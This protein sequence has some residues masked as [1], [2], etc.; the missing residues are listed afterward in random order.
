M[1]THPKIETE[2]KRKSSPHPLEI[3][4]VELNGLLKKLARA[5][6][7]KQKDDIKNDIG[8]LTDIR[9]RLSDTRRK[10]EKSRAK[11]DAGGGGGKGRSRKGTKA[12]EIGHVSINE[13]GEFIV[14]N[15]KGEEE[16]KGKPAL[17][18]FQQEF[19]DNNERP[20]Q[21]L[22]S[23]KI[24][25][26]WLAALKQLIRV[27]TL[28]HNQVTISASKPQAYQVADY[29][30][31]LAEAYIGVSLLGTEDIQFYVDGK[32]GPKARYRGSN[33]ATG[34]TYEGDLWLDEYMWIP[35]YVRVNS[36]AKPMATDP[37]Y[38][39]V[40]LSAPS[41]TT[42]PAWAE[43]LGPDAREGE[44]RRRD[45]PNKRDDGCLRRTITMEDAVAD[46]YDRADVEQLKKEN[47]EDY[48]QL[49]MCKPIDDQFSVFPLSV[50]QKC[51]VDSAAW[52]PLERAEVWAGFD[53]SRSIDNAA[54]VHVQPPTATYKKYRLRF[55]KIWYVNYRTIG[56]DIGDFCRRDNVRKMGM[57]T[58]GPVGNGAFEIVS[59]VF[60]G[61]TEIVHTNETLVQHVARAKDVIGS[62]LF[63]IDIDDVETIN[64]FM[65]IKQGT[66][67]RRHLVTYVTDATKSEGGK[68]RDH[69]D[70]AW[71]VINAL[72]FHEIAKTRKSSFG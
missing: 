26:S 46:G 39:I 42:H 67:A 43:W 21:W 12:N 44:D 4:S 47:P 59:P 18:G 65:R 69:G 55:K 70:L 41:A 17:F 56:G 49:Y 50:M 7:K 5:K 45:N 34:Q 13:A 3:V 54:Y 53:P 66:T 68:R 30:K 20:Q 72:S 1:T 14:K 64:S 61:V 8:F 63:E 71:A 40:K 62:G 9:E 2:P 60:S 10:N 29:L 6:G 24:G 23:R 58:T 57:D 25:F 22:K 19:I 32:R 11:A 16:N 33:A 31:I 35:D 28:G 27:I 36:A 15:K 51:Q 52:E 37:K 38:I 48:D